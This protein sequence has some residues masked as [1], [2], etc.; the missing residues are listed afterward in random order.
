MLNI[1]ILISTSLA[2]FLFTFGLR[3][4]AHAIN[5]CASVFNE[6]N[7]PNPTQL[8]ILDFINST[9]GLNENSNLIQIKP[10]VLKSVFE[11]DV[12]DYENTLL[13]LMGP[14]GDELTLKRLRQFYESK[15]FPKDLIKVRLRMASKVS[16]KN[17]L[18]VLGDL[19]FQET[20]RLFIGTA[21]EIENGQVNAD[22]LIGRYL[23]ESNS[24]LSFRP[25]EERAESNPGNGLKVGIERMIIPVSN[26]TLEIWKKYFSNINGYSVIGHGNLIFNGEV[27]V[28]TSAM[29]ASPMRM[30]SIDTP[31]PFVLFKT[32]EGYRM[33]RYVKSFQSAIKFQKQGMAPMG[34]DN[35][36]RSPWN[37]IPGKNNKSYIEGKG[38]YNCCVHWQGN[39]PIGD[40]LVTEIVL[41]GENNKPV[42]AKLNP[43]DYS[44]PDLA[45]VK[46]VWTY[47]LNEPVSSAIGL[48]DRNGA[49]DFASAGW[50][51][52]TLLISASKERVPFVFMFVEDVKHEFPEVI[53]P[54]YEHPW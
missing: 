42:I 26:D 47:P 14:K 5:K 12:R 53:K 2:L 43:P 23:A 36:A 19:T 22:S 48:A 3:P 52:Q 35:T 33:S 18:A 21:K 37:Q 25:F 8:K 30:P 38:K 16:S 20:Q 39:M 7:L 9:K 41:P 24:K 17:I 45:H 28:Q 15:Y 13:E 31:L 44:D 1:K 49:G 27:L 10:D 11:H 4:E 51:I 50:V 34:W 40:K 46:D 29:Q 54:T 32:T 6:S